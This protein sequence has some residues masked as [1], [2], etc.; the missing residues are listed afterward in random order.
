MA[1]TKK[2]PIPVTM[3]ETLGFYGKLLSGGAAGSAA[4]ELKDRPK[5]IE[6]KVN[7]Y[8][9]GGLVKAGKVSTQFKV[10]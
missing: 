1:E 7:G 10:K 4:G 2:P 9:S 5:K 3:K 8:K 6:E